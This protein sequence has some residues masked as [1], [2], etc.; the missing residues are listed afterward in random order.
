MLS[1]LLSLGLLACAHPSSQSATVSVPTQSKANMLAPELKVYVGSLK[2]KPYFKSIRL[3]GKR[4]Y[5]KEEAVFGQ[6]AIK[7]A[8]VS[9]TINDLPALG[10]RLLPEEA[11][12][13]QKHQKN[14]KFDA[15]F[16]FVD[17]MLIS[18]M[19]HHLTA[20]QDEVLLVPMPS[21]SLARDLARK[22]RT[23]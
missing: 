2:S 15:V 3:N 17:K 6:H 19:S 7:T 18:T 20:L 14:L 1:A 4:Y 22:I 9:K 23:Y 13:Y 21:L 5:I 8:F 11:K 16:V 12:Q 10:L